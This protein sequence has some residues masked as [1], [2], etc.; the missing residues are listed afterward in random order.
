MMCCLRFQALLA[1]K[2][3]QIEQIWNDLTAAT[4]KYNELSERFKYTLQ[5]HGIQC[6]HDV[7]EMV[8]V[9]KDEYFDNI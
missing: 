5:S 6:E 3:K 9:K 8:T 7:F 2:N 1:K 4:K